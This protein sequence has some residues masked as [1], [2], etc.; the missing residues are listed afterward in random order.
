MRYVVYCAQW[1]FF[2]IRQGHLERQAVN[3]LAQM[4]LEKIVRGRA[5]LQ[6]VS[7]CLTTCLWNLTQKSVLCR[8]STRPAVSYRPLLR[9][10][11]TIV[12]CANGKQIGWRLCSNTFASAVHFGSVVLLAVREDKGKTL[13]TCGCRTSLVQF[14]IKICCLKTNINANAFAFLL[15]VL[16][17]SFLDYLFY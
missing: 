16:R 3:C 9:F 17:A 15:A 11:I 14:G 7:H 13:P 1:N 10:D 12:G 6:S 4:N 5:L 8:L 2:S